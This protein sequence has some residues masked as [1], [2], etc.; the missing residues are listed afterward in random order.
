MSF[1]KTVRNVVFALSFV[2]ELCANACAQG[3]LPELIREPIKNDDQP[4]LEQHMITFLDMLNRF[5]KKYCVKSTYSQLAVFDEN[6]SRSLFPK[7]VSGVHVVV[8]DELRKQWRAI[9]LYEEDG[10]VDNYE[11]YYDGSVIFERPGGQNYWARCQPYGGIVRT[12]GYVNPKNFHELRINTIHETVLPPKFFTV[13]LDC[14]ASKSSREISRGLF[15]S[16]NGK[17]PNLNFEVTFDARALPLKICFNPAVIGDF[18]IEK[19]CKKFQEFP[20]HLIYPFVTEL[21][22][23]KV[24]SA[25]VDSD[26]Y[27]IHNCRSEGKFGAFQE[28][29]AE[30]LWLFSP[31]VVDKYLIDPRKENNAPSLKEIRFVENV[32]K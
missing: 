22:W 6:S 9:Q 19:L 14:F 16:K 3:K 7:Q 20:E 1:I 26:I 11:A 21:E 10:R 2:V 29:K 17:G 31:D 15:A 28:F 30:N 4:L 27:A 18:S 12:V 24:K 25:E 8:V 13:D 32:G 23:E 5:P